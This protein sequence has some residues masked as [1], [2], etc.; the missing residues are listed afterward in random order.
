MRIA[1]LLALR[2]W[3]VT[4]TLAVLFLRALLTFWVVLRKGQSPASWG[5]LARVLAR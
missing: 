3:E 2:G 1:R 5:A 4:D